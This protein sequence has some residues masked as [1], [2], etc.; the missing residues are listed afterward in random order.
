MSL[1]TFHYNPMVKEINFQLFQGYIMS[2]IN[3]SVI[4]V[5]KDK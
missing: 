2:F 1:K 4:N 3:S 5:F